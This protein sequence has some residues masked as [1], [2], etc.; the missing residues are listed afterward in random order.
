[1]VGLSLLAFT[2][3]SFPVPTF[4]QTS[5]FSTVVNFP[6]YKQLSAVNPYDPTIDAAGNIYGTSY[7]GES[8]NL[9]TV[10]KVTPINRR[11]LQD[12]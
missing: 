1:M 6:R 5:T 12:R 2:T 10:W 8:K 9:G 3:F 4:A 11:S 7:T